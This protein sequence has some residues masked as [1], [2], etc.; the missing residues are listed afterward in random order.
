[1]GWECCGR[2]GTLRPK[3]RPGL[4][5]MSVV[6]CLLHPPDPANAPELCPHND[7]GILPQETQDSSLPTAAYSCS[8]H[9]TLS[10]ILPQHQRIG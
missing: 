6:L 9:Q 4:L 3:L 8:L 10:I 1:M 5:S 7:V 2:E